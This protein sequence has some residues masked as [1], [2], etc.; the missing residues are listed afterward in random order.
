ALAARRAPGGRGRGGRRQPFRL[1]AR[2]RRRAHRSTR[3]LGGAFRIGGPGRASA[4]W[5]LFVS[6]LLLS[7]ALGAPIGA[8]VGAAIGWAPVFAVLAGLSLCL[9]WPNFAIWPRDPGAA[10]SGE[11][12][13]ALPAVVVARR[14]MPMVMW[15]TALYGMYT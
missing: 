4:W 12:F 6:G 1:C 10:A 3:P 9:V 5:A 7:L 15:S 14:L 8:W 11:R 13:Q 2:R